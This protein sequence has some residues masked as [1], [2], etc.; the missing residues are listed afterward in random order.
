[1]NRRS[2]LSLAGLAPL[3]PAKTAK[4]W[5]APEISG[6]RG[7]YGRVVVSFTPVEGAATYDLQCTPENGEPR[8]V[9][10]VLAADYTLHG[11]ENGRRYSFRVAAVGPRGKT[12][13]SA[14]V[15]A[16]PAAELSWTT[17]AE[18]FQGDNPTRSSCPF[19][20]VHGNESD[21]DLRRF[22][23]ICYQFGFEGVTL[24]PYDLEDFLGE[25]QWHRWRVVVEHARKLGL[26]VWQ[27]DDRDYPSGYAG[28]MIGAKYPELARWEVTLPYSRV[29]RAGDDVALDLAAV[30]PPKHSTVAVCAL[31]PKGKA[32]DLSGQL[33]SGRVEWRVPQGEWVLFVAAAMQPAFATAKSHPDHKKGQ[34]R[35]YIDPLSERATDLLVETIAGATY[36]QLGAEFGRTWMG[37]F[38][39]EPGFHTSGVRL[40]TPGAGYPYTPDLFE[41][42]EKRFGYS[43]RPLVPLLWTARG[44]L[45]QQ[46]RHDYMEFVT[47]E[48]GRL[49]VAKQRQFAEAHNIRLIGH[50]IELLSSEYGLG[51]G[52]GSTMRTLEHFSMG[53]FDH[54]F[55]QWYEPDED[56]YWRQAKIASSVSHY[57]Q[58]PQDEAMVEHF[59]ATGWRTGLTEMK[60]M[61][62]WTTCRGMNRIVPCGLDTQ[63]PPVW[64]DAP[65]F[66]LRGEN[67]LA[68]HFRDYQVVANRETMMIRGGRHVARA[69][70]LDP[71]ESAWTGRTEDLWKVNKALAL[72]HLDFDNVTY[73]V[74]TDNA[75]CRVEDGKVL[76]GKED[77][78]VV[79]LPGVDG[80]PLAVLEKLVECR[81]KGATVLLIGGGG[82][83]DMQARDVVPKLPFRSADGRAD[84]QV[85]ELARKLWID[86]GESRGRALLVTYKDVTDTLYGLDLHDVW[87]E[88]NLTGLQYYHRVLSGRDL[89][90]FNNEGEAVRTEVRLRGARGTPEFW[91][92]VSGS[93]RQA[94]C[95]SEANGRLSLR[96]ELE[97]YESVFVVVNPEAKPRPWLVEAEAER[98]LRLDSGAIELRRYSP[99]RIRC[100]LAQPGGA[101]SGKEHAT[102]RLPLHELRIGAGWDR[103]PGAANSATYAAR[104]DWQAGADAGAE[105]RIRGMSQVIS[106]RLNGRE[107]G[108][109]FTY[110]FRFDLTAALQPGRNELE[111][112]HVERHTFESKLGDVR[113]V[114]YYRLSL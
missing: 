87:I 84:A 45:T 71:A 105:L 78:R 11:L 62:D 47:G 44:P 59:A 112:H 14:P 20:M 9:E 24:H 58:I 110:P 86:A 32:V 103:A 90:F 42:F 31:G 80:V 75:R 70:V 50:V 66:W 23:D 88:P 36:R 37:F 76:L 67:P 25:G 108:T 22:L 52:T 21:E 28:G 30:L 34:D 7:E 4:P 101:I 6:A 81:D 10:G 94:P 49:F 27:Q 73:R 41:R 29:C 109:R 12:P 104:F 15:T 51:P 60:A 102:P 68:A 40:G 55:D 95:Y 8:T 19:W 26:A 89:Y 56:V 99:G 53:G 38:I 18:A 92:P 77:Y 65:E 64:E 106:A 111:L 63:T 17:L 57:N 33:P 113:I 97:R 48:Y 54:I 39:D 107:M 1:M 5:G 35:R 72:A 69:L 100:R 16:T 82:R 43:L 98:V 83:F 61:M 2:F 96:L 91:D 85:K 93:I 74:F 79:V 114:P 46:V 13:F 3:L